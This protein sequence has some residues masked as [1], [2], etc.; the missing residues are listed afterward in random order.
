MALRPSSGTKH[1][2][3]LAL[4]VSERRSRQLSRTSPGGELRE[5]HGAPNR[6][7]CTSR[8]ASL[9]V[10][11]E[12]SFGLSGPLCSGSLGMWSEQRDQDQGTKMV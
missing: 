5:N 9:V 1:F 7:L 10:C 12:A 6:G 3:S 2:G 8:A 11:E 4:P